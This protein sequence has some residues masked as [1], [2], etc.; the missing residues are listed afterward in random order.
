MSTVPDDRSTVASS[1]PSED[2][3]ALG[4]NIIRVS[5]KKLLSMWV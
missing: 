1:T 3:Y 4:W 2:F 5:R